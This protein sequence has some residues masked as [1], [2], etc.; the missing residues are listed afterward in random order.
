MLLAI[1]KTKELHHFT[2]TKMLGY[3]RDYGPDR[4]KKS[5]QL[6]TSNLHQ[7]LEQ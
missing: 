3:G 4:N 5:R 6:Y 7:V 2:Y 1:Q